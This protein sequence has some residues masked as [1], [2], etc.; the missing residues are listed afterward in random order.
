MSSLISRI[1]LPLPRRTI[2]SNWNIRNDSSHIHAI[3]HPDNV[4]SLRSQGEAYKKSALVNVKKKCCLS[5]NT[6]Y[7][8]EKTTQPKI[9]AKPRNC[10]SLME[11]KL[12]PHTLNR[13]SIRECLC[14]GMHSVVF[15][16]LFL[17]KLKIYS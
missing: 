6:C 5:T 2:F 11:K 10:V 4:Y 3:L 12:G 15:F 13:K 9:V 16:R 7:C 17:N 8:K 14:A 1:A